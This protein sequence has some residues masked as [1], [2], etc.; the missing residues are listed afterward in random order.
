MSHHSE[1]HQSPP[2]K[3]PMAA[4]S[5]PEP[6]NRIAGHRGHA[7]RGWSKKGPVMPPAVVWIGGVCSCAVTV[8][9]L[10]RVF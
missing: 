2:A 8:G 9:L 4:L 1:P 7:R 3:S 10:A 6:P 5:V